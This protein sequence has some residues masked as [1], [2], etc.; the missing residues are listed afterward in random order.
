MTS[1]VLDASAGAEIA[2]RML[3]RSLID[4]QRAASALDRL[5]SLPVVVARSHPL[6]AEAWTLRA[7]L[8]VHDALYVVLARIL[9]A[10]LLTGDRR[11][12]GAPN[13]PVPVLHLS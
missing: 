3:L 10:P 11:M 8:I 2:V 13:L 4:E 1:V 6:I 5:L 7:N 9:D 12:A